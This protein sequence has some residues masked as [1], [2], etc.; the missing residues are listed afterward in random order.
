MGELAQVAG[1]RGLR[2]VMGRRWEEGGAPRYWPWTQVVRSVGGDLERQA[3]SGEAAAPGRGA[4]AGVVPEGDRLRLF[5]AVGRFLA[6]A[7]SERP[8]LVT[9]DDVNATD[10]ASLLLL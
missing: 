10:E 8:L 1:G 7:A 3:A 6:S 2:V 9:L 5:D 4:A